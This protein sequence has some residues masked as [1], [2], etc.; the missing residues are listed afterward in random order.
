MSIVTEVAMTS[1]NEPSPTATAFSCTALLR[2]YGSVIRLANRLATSPPIVNML[3][4]Y[5]TDVRI[6]NKTLEHKWRDSMSCSRLYDR[7][8]EWR[9][10]DQTKACLVHRHAN[11]KIKQPKVRRAACQSL[12]D[13][14]KLGN[15]IAIL[16]WSQTQPRKNTENCIATK[17]CH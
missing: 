8:A 7:A 10:T 14:V 4:T 1:I 5:D 3:V 17:G 12:L 2:P 9:L 15:G 13:L 16:E 6:H 11:R